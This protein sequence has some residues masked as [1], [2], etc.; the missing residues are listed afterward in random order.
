MKPRRAKT[1]RSSVSADMMARNGRVP[2][3]SPAERADRDEYR[4]VDQPGDHAS[5]PRPPLGMHPG[6]AFHQHDVPDVPGRA[7]PPAN[8][9]RPHEARLDPGGPRGS[10]TA[11]RPAPPTCRG[12]AATQFG[13]HAQVLTLGKRPELANLAQP[14]QRAERCS[15]SS[16]AYQREST[17]AGFALY[18]SSTT[19]VPSRAR[20]TSG[21][22]ALPLLPAPA[23]SSQPRAAPTRARSP[24]SQQPAP[25]T[26]PRPPATRVRAR[27]PASGSPRSVAGAPHRAR[28]ARRTL[29]A[30]GRSRSVRAGERAIA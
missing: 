6:D 27:A 14:H 23:R 5:S 4:I 16:R 26:H 11:S 21:A 7:P 2:S 15:A 20:A 25:H 13:A 8:L 10:S 12:A 29:P 28:D 3:R 18:A 24:R 19:I 22:R 17:L 1:R 30:P 9:P